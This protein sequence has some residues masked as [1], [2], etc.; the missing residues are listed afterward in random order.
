[1]KIYTGGKGQDYVFLLTFVDRSDQT[2][3]LQ[4][5]SRWW[6]TKAEELEEVEE[7]KIPAAQIDAADAEEEE[8]DLD[9]I[10]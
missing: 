7:E 2:I 5:S 4:Q 10:L 9:H 6:P 1:L 3:R 8:E